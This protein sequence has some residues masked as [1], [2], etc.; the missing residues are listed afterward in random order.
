MTH[1]FINN[2]NSFLSNARDL[3]NRGDFQASKSK[4][5]MGCFDF[6]K[7]KQAVISASQ[8]Q[9]KQPVYTQAVDRWANYQQ[10]MPL[11]AETLQPLIDE[12]QQQLEN[13][14]A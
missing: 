14:N 9:V 4:F 3:Y 11:K 5:E 1:S 12:Y 6:H 7:S 13:A 10:L 2:F 8:L